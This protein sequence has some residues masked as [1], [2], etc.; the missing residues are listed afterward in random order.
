[1]ATQNLPDVRLR[2]MEPEDLDFLYGIEN[3]KKIWNV[4]ATNVPYSRYVLHEYVANTRNDIYADRQVRLIITDKESVPVGITDL[5]NF[6]P[7]HMRAEIG[8]VIC[9]GHRRKGYA[10][11]ALLQMTDYAA[12]TLNLHQLYAVIPDTHSASLTLFKSLGFT[13]TA[14]LKDWLNNGTAYQNVYIMQFLIKK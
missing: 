5:T 3:D 1:M 10:R 6:D 7:R 2:A 13:V 11:A 12:H 8:I 14:Q 4:S 9:N